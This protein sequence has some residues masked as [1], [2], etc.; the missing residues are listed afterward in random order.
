MLA[1]ERPRVVPAISTN[2]SFCM[3]NEGEGD[4]KT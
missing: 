4:S 2:Q 1:V 3:T